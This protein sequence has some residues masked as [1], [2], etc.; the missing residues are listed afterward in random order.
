MR[1]VPE[2][3]TTLE[4]YQAYIENFIRHK[5]KESVLS[6]NLIYV[7]RSA[8]RKR[9]EEQGEDA[10]FSDL[11]PIICGLD[12]V[13]ECAY[14]ET[15]PSDYES[16]IKECGFTDDEIKVLGCLCEGDTYRE[17]EQS[18]GKSKSTIGNMVEALRRKARKYI[19][20]S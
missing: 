5:T 8:F 9:L 16:F 15:Y 7:P 10:D 3:I 18:L 1:P 20:R 12:T 14:Y 6:D 2:H 11:I 4:H 13:K 19:R 17:I